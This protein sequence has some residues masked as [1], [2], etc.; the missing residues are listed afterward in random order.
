[1][2]DTNFLFDESYL[3]EG[4]R[5]FQ[6]Q[7]ELRYMIFFEMQYQRIMNNANSLFVLFQQLNANIFEQKVA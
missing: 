7:L 2:N 1:M 5:C 4:K 3:Q 6:E